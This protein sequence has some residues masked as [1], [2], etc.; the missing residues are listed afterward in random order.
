MQTL[1]TTA[2]DGLAGNEDAGQMSA[3]YMFSALGFYPVDPVSGQYVLGSPEVD[4]ATLYLE[5]G[6]EFH[7]KTLNQSPEHIYV[8]SVRLNGKTLSGF[9]LSHADILQGGELEFVMS[10]TPYTGAQEQKL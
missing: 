9:T 1:Y 5:N 4:S 8:Q 7:I 3:W 10:A 6:K 2:P